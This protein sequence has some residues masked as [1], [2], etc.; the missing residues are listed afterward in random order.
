VTAAEK[1]AKELETL[2]GRP[3]RFVHPLRSED[4]P[5]LMRRLGG[6]A[7]YDLDSIVTLLPGKK[8][9]V[10]DADA[11]RELL[12]KMTP[13]DWKSLR[14][15]YGLQTTA[16]ALTPSA[17]LDVFLDLV[18]DHLRKEGMEVRRLPLLTVPVALLRNRE[19]LTHDEFLIT[20]NNV[21]A[22]TRAGRLRAEGFASLI[23]AGDRMAR[24]AF[25]AAGAQLDLL[26]PLIRS[27]ILNGGY[28]CASNH[29]RGVAGR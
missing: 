13:E 17:D 29:V 14:G 11:G 26:P 1:A 18:A 3:V 15:G 6:G 10:A 12:S 7:G 9:L 19:G 24:E 28:R 21:V 22:E 23:P 20:W 4:G 25:A 16:D 27:V 2:Y 8:A 5:T